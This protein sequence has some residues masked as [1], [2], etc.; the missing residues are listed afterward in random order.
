VRTHKW[1]PKGHYGP[2]RPFDSHAL[3]LDCPGARK[4]TDVGMGSRSSRM[5]HREPHCPTKEM[6]SPDAVEPSIV[7]WRAFLVALVDLCGARCRM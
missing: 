6:R 3:P 7:G 4:S 1:T 5:P 2:M